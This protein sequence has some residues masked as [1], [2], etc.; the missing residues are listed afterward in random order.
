[1]K[2]TLQEVRRIAR[3]AHLQFSNAEVERLRGDLDRILAYVDKLGELDTTSVEP[4]VAPS[5]VMP[6]LREDERAGTLPFEEAVAN[7]PESGQGHFK[8]PRVIG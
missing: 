1:M 3:L 5:G 8:V 4:A 7:A 2:I 6:P